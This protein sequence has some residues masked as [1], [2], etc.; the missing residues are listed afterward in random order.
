MIAFILSQIIG[1]T[2]FLVLNFSIFCYL[3]HKKSTTPRTKDQ[4]FFL[5]YGYQ[6]LFIIL[7]S[8][9]TYRIYVLQS[10]SDYKYNLWRMQYQLI[11]KNFPQL[12][13]KV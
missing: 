13:T 7:F 11:L 1:I 6:I 8:G 4:R 12:H 10:H 3:R 9:L 2:T 5:K